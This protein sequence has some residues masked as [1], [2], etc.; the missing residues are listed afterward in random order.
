MPCTLVRVTDYTTTPTSYE[1]YKVC[2]PDDGGD[3]TY[4]PPDGPGS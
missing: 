4:R 2:W 1:S 3:D